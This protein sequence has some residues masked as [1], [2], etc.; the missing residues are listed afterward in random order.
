MRHHRL[1]DDLT[2]DMGVEGPSLLAM[3]EEA[4]PTLRR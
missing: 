1:L 4:G 3:L 2:R